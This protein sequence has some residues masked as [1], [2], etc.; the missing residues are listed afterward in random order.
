MCDSEGE[1]DGV[2]GALAMLERA[3]DRLN[4]TD[5]ASLPAGPRNRARLA[6]AAPPEPR[7]ETLP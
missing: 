5:V 7:P 2:G 3:L 6:V 1:A 4:A